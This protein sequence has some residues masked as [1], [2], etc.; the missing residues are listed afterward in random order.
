MKLFK[1]LV[2]EAHRRSLWQVLGVYAVSSWV[3]LEVAGTLTS[4]LGLPDWVPSLSLVL[5]VVGL[6]VVLA[7][8]FVQEGGPGV[9]GGRPERDEADPTPPE[10]PIPADVLAHPFLKRHLTWR[11][12]LLG[13][14]V[15]FS[16]L[17]F[18]AGGYMVSW[19]AG[20]GPWGSLLAQGNLEE[21]DRILLSP[22]ANSTDDPAWGPLVTEALRIDLQQL[23][24]LRVLEPGSEEV[25]AILGRM[26]V[27][28]EEPFGPALAREVALRGGY[29]AYL[30]GEVGRLGA[31]YVLTSTLRS[32]DSG[33][34]LA[35]FR[36]TARSDDELVPALDRFSRKVRE[37]LG[38]PLRSIYASPPLAEVTTSSLD[39]LRL[40][41]EATNLM[42]RGDPRAAI[43]LVEE[44]LELDPDFAMAWR[45]LALAF[46]RIQRERAREFEAITRAYQLSH[47]LPPRE[48]LLV[49]AA[50]YCCVSPNSD[51]T[52][53]AYRRMLDL[54]PDDVAALNNLGNWFW[55]T[56]EYDLAAEHFERASRVPDPAPEPFLNLIRLRL[57]QGEPDQ[58]ARELDR[59]AEHHAEHFGVAD[60]RF[61]LSLID[62]DVGRAR[63]ALDPFV[64]DPSRAVGVTSRLW[65]AALWEGRIAEARRRFDEGRRV[66]ETQSDAAGQLLA[67]L[68]SAHA[69]IALGD[70]ER[71][72]AGYRRLVESGVLADLT[73]PDRWHFFQALVL[74]LGGLPDEA[75]EMLRRF[76]EDVP[77]EFHDR[78]QSENRSV[79]AFVAI[80]RGNP[81]EAVRILEEL[82]D[83][84]SCRR[85]YADRMGW[86]LWEA[87]KPEEA[88][89][90]WEAFL[91]WK[92]LVHGLE[93]Q[94]QRHLWV[95]QRIGPLYEEL[96]D[97][98]RALF[99]YRRLARLWANAD[100]DLQPVVERARERIVALEGR[101]PTD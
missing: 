46:Q 81:S 1:H 80:K 39:A 5:L 59:F 50:Y 75:E 70:R 22:F 30:E 13:G 97:P 63:G 96:E 29:E 2:V 82:R 65:V 85:C 84:M 83:S 3:V 34:A 90:E 95:L 33:E 61:W 45:V 86:A 31:G 93:F 52:F 76:D 17:A 10:G 68:Q 79:Q 77:P 28:Q 21:G 87:G 7:T 40:F 98:A 101:V 19:A 24:R 16:L 71:G 35:S 53:Q 44:A 26:R 41:T 4:V 74:A 72:L 66:R 15:A 18:L 100:A 51:A 25:R 62:D 43:P 36:E 48:R 54:D 27:D 60:W 42:D 14:A 8:A 11:R 49:Q 99:H 69:E 57:L 58:A 56:G 20:M 88:A 91:S 89:Q 73:P 67:T 94:A 37:R 47:R 23:P 6:P 38:E 64:T 9:K 78:F 32:T 92:D 12:A 55:G